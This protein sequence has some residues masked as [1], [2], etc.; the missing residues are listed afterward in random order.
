MSDFRARIVAELDTSKIP[1]SIKKIEKQNITLRNFS[2]D[3]KGL[4]S[5]IQASLDKH[6]FTIKLDGLK[7][8]ILILQPV[9]LRN[10]LMIFS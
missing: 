1:S 3:T 10:L 6:K 7:H 8:L 4:P 5:Q 2:L 9:E